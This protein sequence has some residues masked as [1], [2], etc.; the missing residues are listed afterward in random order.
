MLGL[1]ILLGD[2][3]VVTPLGLPAVEAAAPGSRETPPA[4]AGFRQFAQCPAALAC[5]SFRTPSRAAPITAGAWK[6]RGAK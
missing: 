5:G 6:L 4:P 3:E 2:M 1:S